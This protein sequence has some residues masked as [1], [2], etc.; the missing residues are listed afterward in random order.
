MVTNQKSDTIAP[1]FERNTLMNLLEKY[2]TLHKKNVSTI[3][4][5]RTGLTVVRYLHPG[6]DFSDPELRMARSLALTEDGDIAIRGFEKFFNHLQYDNCDWV[7]EEF[8][9][10]FTRMGDIETTEKNY[11]LRKN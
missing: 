5:E 6:L 7:T 2:K 3:Y 10:Q 4:D 9:E 11:F 8:K 1:F